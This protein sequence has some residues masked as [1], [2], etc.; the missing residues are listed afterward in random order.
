MGS[1][2]FARR[3]LR[4]H[5]YFLFLRLLRCFSS[6][7]SLRMTMDSCC[8]DGGSLR[9]VSPFG[10]LRIEGYLHLPAAF[11][12]LSRPSSAPDAKAFPLRSFMLDLPLRLLPQLSNNKRDGP[13]L[14]L[15]HSPP[16]VLFTFPSRYFALSVTKEYLAL[17]GGPRSFHQG[18]TCLGVLWILLRLLV[19]RL[20]GF[21]LLWLTFPMSFY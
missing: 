11:R 5:C 4:N 12:S 20:R 7:G 16:G 13:I 15:F 1:S 17:R 21:H 18:S 8:A 9:R 14:V 19:F 2:A 3:Y 6:P 10:Y